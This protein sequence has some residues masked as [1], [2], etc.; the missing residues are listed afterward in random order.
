MPPVTVQ[1][2]PLSTASVTLAVICSQSFGFVTVIFPA[3]SQ[4]LSVVAVSGNVDR[5]VEGRG[6][7]GCVT[8]DGAATDFVS[9]HL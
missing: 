7:A 6:A 2:P 9:F 4:P 3:T 5:V 1:V 8:V